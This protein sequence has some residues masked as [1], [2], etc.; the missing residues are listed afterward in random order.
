[1]ENF[2]DDFWDTQLECEEKN[3]LCKSLTTLLIT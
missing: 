3:I 2:I 1:M